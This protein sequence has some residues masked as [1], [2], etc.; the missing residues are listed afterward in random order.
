MNVLDV[1]RYGNRTL[2]ASLE[3]LPRDDWQVGG[4]CGVWSVKDIVAHLA[5]YE[6]MLAEALATFLGEGMGPNLS[7]RAEL[8][9]DWNDL[10]V[11]RRRYMTVAEVLAEYNEVN[12]QVLGLAARIPGEAY[13]RNGTIPWYG[14]EYCLNDLI[15]YASYGH[16]REHSAQVNVYRD[17][18]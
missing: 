3:S 6:H 13:R 10:Q 14:P 7:E 12:E 8:G 18:L 2:L 15:V 17:G 9:P 11:D 1:L 16:K 4:V 5:S